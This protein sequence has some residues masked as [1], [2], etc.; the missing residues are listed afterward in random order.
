MGPHIDQLAGLVPL[1]MKSGDLHQADQAIAAAS[2]LVDAEVIEFWKAHLLRYMGKPDQARTALTRTGRKLNA[3]EL[4]LLA[5]IQADLGEL[6]ESLVS[7]TRVLTTEKKTDPEAHAGIGMTYLRRGY[8]E[9][10]IESL[11]QAHTLDPDA[12]AY[13]S[14]LASAYTAA[15]KPDQAFKQVLSALGQT[16]DDPVLDFQMKQSRKGRESRSK[17]G[18]G[19]SATVAVLGFDTIGGAQERPGLGQLVTSM[20]VT[21]FVSKGAG[22][23]VER[24]RIEDLLAE[25]DLQNTSRF[26]DATAVDIGNLAGAKHL[27]VGNVAEFADLIRIDVRVLDT[28]SGKVLMASSATTAV[29]LPEIGTGLESIV[30]ELDMD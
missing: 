17:T 9:L 29:A 30:A 24:E 27:V 12:P 21:E 15:G 18:S 6:D 3:D 20:F 19:V 2:E 7:W 11:L 4:M 5:Q 28:R 13:L 16:P 22:R 25:Q 14:A 26:D 1:L 23:V 8:V 10:A